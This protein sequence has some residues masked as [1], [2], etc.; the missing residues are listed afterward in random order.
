MEVLKKHV[1][2]ALV[3]QYSGGLGSAELMNGLPLT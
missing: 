1:D 2:V 3:T